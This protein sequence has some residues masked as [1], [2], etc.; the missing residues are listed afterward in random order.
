M[1]RGMQ[2]RSAVIDPPA[3][4]SAAAA[5]Q[6]GAWIALLTLE[7][8]ALRMAVALRPMVIEPDGA[9][10][11]RLAQEILRGSGERGFHPAW[12]PFYPA[13]IAAARATP[14]TA[15]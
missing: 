8:I 12:P 5:R 14:P 15:S 2:E 4:D 1:G 11:A 7:A 6:T 13:L 10:Y 3:P 9:F